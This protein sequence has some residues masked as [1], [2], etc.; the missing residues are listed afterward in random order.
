MAVG[1]KQQN[2]N[3]GLANHADPTSA[4]QPSTRLAEPAP[5]QLVLTTKAE[6]RSRQSRG[7][8][9]GVATIRVIRGIRVMA[10]G[11]NKKA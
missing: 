6:R 7:S 4:L 2:L 8:D 3:A 10:V 1:L 5:W 9:L 11:L